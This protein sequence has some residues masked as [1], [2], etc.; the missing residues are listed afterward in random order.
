MTFFSTTLG[1]TLLVLTFLV[2]TNLGSGYFA[3]RLGYPSLWGNSTGIFMEY[4]VPMLYN[5]AL[6][7]VV[8]MVPIAVVLSRVPGWEAKSVFMFR[9]VAGFVLVSALLLEVKLPVGR[10]N[11]V[12]FLLFIIMDTSL[13]L[14][15][16]VIFYP[17]LKGILG[18]T[19]AG[20]LLYSGLYLYNNPGQL[21]LPL[22]VDAPEVD[23]P[24]VESPADG[25]MEFFE[26]VLRFERPGF[27]EMDAI[28]RET[29]GPNQGP[30]PEEI[31]D[32]AKLLAKSL[33]RSLTKS[34]PVVVKFTAHPW[35][36]SEDKY[37]Y[38]AGEAELDS[39]GQW[40]CNFVYPRP[41][42]P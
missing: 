16:T 35:F 33:V 21:K 36:E 37:V 28:I 26:K 15:L 9:C 27:I 17:P 30:T 20:L 10:L 3:V 42:S 24:E 34:A 40:H 8:F 18:V 39:A 41:A 29:V 38:P 22:K 14:L 23:E 2:C 7:H 5:W 13:A 32:N 25:S 31:C 4:A 6:A 12:P 11:H 1:R 19:V